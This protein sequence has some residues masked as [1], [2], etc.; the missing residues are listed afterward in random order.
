MRRSIVLKLW[1]ATFGMVVAVLLP[2]G[3]AVNQTFTNYYFRHLAHHLVEQGTTFA[4]ML[5]TDPMAEMMLP[6]IARSARAGVML[7]DPQGRALLWTDLPRGAE[8][9]VSRAQLAAV[10]G[11][12]IAVA[13]DV[14]I[15]QEP[16]VAVAVP[17]PGPTKEVRGAL[18]LMAPMGPALTTLRSIRQLML[19]AGL[20]AVLLST[21]LA[22]VLSLTLA[23]PLIRME[24]ATRTIAQGDYSI[25]VPVT[26]QDEVAVLGGAIN[27]LA[28][29]L[30]R[31]ERSRREFLANVSH[32]LRT[33]LSYLRGYSQA[34]VDGVVKTPDE[35]AQHHQII[36]E[37]AIRLGRLVEDLTDLARVEE[38]YLALHRE[39]VA[40]PAV[41]RS[42]LGKLAPRAAAQ[43]I[44]LQEEWPPAL[45]PVWADP[46]RVEQVL[47]N[48]LDN[49]LRHTPAGGRVRVAGTIAGDLV[50]VT[51]KDTGSGI[52]A[53]ELPHIWERFHRVDKSRARGRGGLGL[54]LAI[55]RSIIRAHG[56]EVGA[57]SEPGQGTVIWFTLP[58]AGGQD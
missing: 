40:L 9:A 5:V 48:L 56:G 16:H 7:I 26:G 47:L 14:K 13:R 1:A 44:A 19:L 25:R 42:A 33:P 8:A 15:N 35:Q 34:L 12:Q 45:A 18:L 30:D 2:L 51:V 43:G 20:G 29:A 46:G 17:V 6:V 21:G 58:V 50:R 37:E 4:G 53:E 52:P 28:A 41:A 10:L 32:E 55:V 49:A 27:E 3:L 22:F 57:E 31:Y 38:G 23:R 11:G 54:G 24:R 36:L 39:A